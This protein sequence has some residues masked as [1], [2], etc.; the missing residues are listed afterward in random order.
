ML[1]PV[2]GGIPHGVFSKMGPGGNACPLT[3][4][5][6]RWTDKHEPVQPSHVTV[7]RHYKPQADTE[8][9]GGGRVAG[10]GSA[11]Q[12]ALESKS[13][14]GKIDSVTWSPYL[15][16]NLLSGSGSVSESLSDKIPAAHFET[17]VQIQDQ[18]AEVDKEPEGAQ[19]RK[20]TTS[21]KESAN[22]V[23]EQEGEHQPEME[24]FSFCQ[25]M[26]E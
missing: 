26:M 10:S 7:E 19:A 17:A 12:Y 24:T 6:A 13:K 5:E 16:V 3:E 20:F 22:P 23:R 2:G 21:S 1:T 14:G 11:E 4:H 8:S 15:V 25:I 18:T 9:R